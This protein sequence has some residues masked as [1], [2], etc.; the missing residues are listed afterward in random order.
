MTA[1]LGK[2]FSFGLLCMSF[3]NVYRFVC[4]LLS[5]LV[6]RVGGGISLYLFLIIAFLFTLL[7]HPLYTEKRARRKNARLFEDSW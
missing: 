7:L 1:G 6:L 5:L 4:A 2:S 3:V